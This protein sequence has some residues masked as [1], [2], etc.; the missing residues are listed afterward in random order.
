MRIERISLYKIALPLLFPLEVSFGRWTHRHSVLVRVEGEGLEGWGECPAGAFPDYNAETWVTVLYVLKTFLIPPLFD[1]DVRGLADVTQSMSRVR[2]HAFAKTGL[3]WAVLD[4]LARAEGISLAQKLGGTRSRAPVGVSLGI[5][6]DIEELMARVEEFLA[7]GYARIKLKIK[8]GWDIH[9]VETFRSRHPN[10]SLMVDANNAY[11]LHHLPVF[12][13][14][15][16]MELLMIEQPLEHDDIYFH[17]LLQKELRT[18]ITLDE[19][20]QSPLHARAAIALQACRAI[21][22]K[23]ARMSGPSAAVAVHDICQ[24]AGMPVWHGGMLETGVGRVANIA[25]AALPNFRFPADIS[26]SDRYFAED[27]IDP[28][29]VLNSDSTVSVP[30]G[31]G[32]GVDVKLDLV[33]SLAQIKEVIE[34]K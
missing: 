32:L 28:P 13:A 23:P 3:E 25:M 16:E 24:N 22:I 10:V 2:G 26:A 33:E 9:V 31:P 1:L 18:P 34:R 29:V 4:W 19:S 5:E 30:R 17:S 27:I 11:R 8:P 20:I 6:P 15:D 21:N 7:R 14:L 12:Q